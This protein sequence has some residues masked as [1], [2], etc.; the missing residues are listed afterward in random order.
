MTTQAND[1]EYLDL[2]ILEEG[3]CDLTSEPG[4]ADSDEI[5]KANS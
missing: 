1:E 5:E 4:K 3:K 2:S